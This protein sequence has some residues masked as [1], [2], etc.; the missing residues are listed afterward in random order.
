M[1]WL[2]VGE[3]LTVNK[4]IYY[5]SLCAKY[6]AVQEDARRDRNFLKHRHAVLQEHVNMAHFMNT[7]HAEITKDWQTQTDALELRANTFFQ[8]TS[9]ME[10]EQMRTQLRTAILKAEILE[11]EQHMIL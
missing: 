1:N 11:K 10:N 7:Q 6:R 3:I 5:V 9:D 8:Q 4:G 2:K